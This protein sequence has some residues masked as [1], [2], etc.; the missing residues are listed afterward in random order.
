MLQR[1]TQP[2]K[3]RK[4][5]TYDLEW[6]PGTDTRKGYEAMALRLVGVYDGNRYRSYTSIAEF[7]NCE[8]TT[9]NSG[10][11]FYAHF[12]GLADIQ[13]VLEYMLGSQTSYEIECS[14]SGSSAIIVSIKR[15]AQYW[16]F[17]DS[18]WLIR[19][20]LRSIGEWLGMNK[21]GGDTCVECGLESPFS[22]CPNCGHS[23]DSTDVFYASL[24]ILR[25]YNEQDCLILY[26]AIRTF[27]SVLE[28]L[29]GRLERTIA[30]TALHLF[31][32][33]YLTV[34]IPTSEKVNEIGRKAYV[35]SRVEDYSR[36][37]GPVNYYDINSSFPHSMLEPQPGK[38]R[39][40]RKRLVES[41][42]CYL[43]ELTISVPNCHIPPLPYRSERTGRVFFPFGVWRSW[44]DS[45]DVR[46]LLGTGGSI[47]QVHNVAYFHPFT[48]LQRYASELYRMR[49]DSK[50]AAFRIVTKYLL[51]SLYGKFAE[52]PEK[53]CLA[54]RPSKIDRGS[55]VMIRPGVWLCSETKD[56]P[57]A[58]VP[59]SAHITSIGRAALTGHMYR[60]KT[61]HYVD[62]DSVLTPSILPT[63]SEL[64]ELKLEYPAASPEAPDGIVSASFAGPKFYRLSL[65]DGR[66]V[67]KAKG[68]S[69]LSSE[70]YDALLRGESIRTTR[71][72]RVRENIRRG[73]SSPI[74]RA[75]DKRLLGTIKP[76]RCHNDSYTS[77]PWN[78]QEL[79]ED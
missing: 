60:A 53:Q 77:R 66:K 42:P 2:F 8:L 38:L 29:G 78:V 10:A 22:A 45:A 15:G 68:F 48:D 70:G 12:G 61:V 40:F 30:S 4:V 50:D 41:E 74:E 75:Y 54:I 59:I 21:G 49:R 37:T 39:C 26:Q 24:D 62:C 56:V 55:M 13:Y 33:A 71:M 34:D 79:L 3:R 63:G 64:G 27:E 58:H 19:S 76:K 67:V 72:V 44:F 16:T 1:S 35:A 51:N 69:K 6:I 9:R 20:S 11:W 47:E 23:K 14:F 52:R 18:G 7:L 25:N 43:A 73:G 65:G 31:R 46:L 28:S 57:H 36:A 5:I 17:L 32:R